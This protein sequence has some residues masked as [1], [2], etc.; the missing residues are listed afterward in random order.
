MASPVGFTGRDIF[1]GGK[2][3][4]VRSLSSPLGLKDERATSFMSKN[5]RLLARF[6]CTDAEKSALFGESF[7]N[8]F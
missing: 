8:N 3:E 2:L 4:T 7:K 6:V 1:V 5:V